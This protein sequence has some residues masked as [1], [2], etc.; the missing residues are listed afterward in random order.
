MYRSWEIVSHVLVWRQ[1]RETHLNCRLGNIKLSGAST[2]TWLIRH[3]NVLSSEFGRTVDLYAEIRDSHLRGS[4][5][6]T[7][8]LLNYH[9]FLGW[10][11]WQGCLTSHC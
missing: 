11:N 7:L 4:R 1:L 6:G 10:A 8:D 5:A 9:S 3:D 2:D